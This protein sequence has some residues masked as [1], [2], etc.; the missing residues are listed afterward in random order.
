MILFGVILIS[1]FTGFGLLDIL[2]GQA[3]FALFS[4]LTGF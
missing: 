2:V 4:L 3:A 1:Q